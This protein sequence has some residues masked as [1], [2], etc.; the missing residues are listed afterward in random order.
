MW[1]YTSNNKVLIR[2]V[3]R[4]K[5]KG[6]AVSITESVRHLGIMDIELSFYEKLGCNFILTLKHVFGT[7][8]LPRQDN[9]A[10]WCLKE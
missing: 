3:R 8:S 9:Q 2:D 5:E 6:M 7:K 4:L 10:N 1:L